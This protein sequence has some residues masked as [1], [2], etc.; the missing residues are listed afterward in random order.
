MTVSSFTLLQPKTSRSADF[1]LVAAWFTF[2]ATVIFIPFRARGVIWA[3]NIPLLYA[4]YTDFLLFVPDVFMLIS[5]ALWGLSLLTVRRKISLGPIHIW[6]PLLGLTLSGWVSLVDSSDMQLTLYHALR[7]SLLFIFIIFIVNELHSPVWV[8][9]PVAI[10][11]LI[12]SLVAIGQSLMQADLGLQFF[13][14][15]E[16]DPLRAGTSIL[17]SGGI[18]FLRAYGLSDHPNILGGCL[19]FGLL[20]LLAAFIYGIQNKKP[21]QSW[22]M[23][24]IFLI[25]SLA[26]LLTFSRSAWIAFLIGSLLI[27]SVEV[28]RKKSVVLSRVVFLAIACLLAASPFIYRDLP[29]LSGR[30]NADA[31]FSA[32]RVERGS[33]IE[34]V[35]LIAAAKRIFVDHALTGVGLGASV[36]AMQQVYSTFAVNYQPPHLTLLASALETGVFGAA[37][38]FI[39]SGYPLLLFAVQRNRLHIA[40]YLI[41]CGAVLLAILIVG[42]FD[43]YPWGYMTGRYWQWMAWG[44][45]ASAWNHQYAMD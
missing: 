6:V 37:F 38:F 5:L 2:A 28:W 17:E 4:D 27:V 9:I 31:S 10:Q 42:I 8:V 21:A 44:L 24:S 3:R 19:A 20:I 22:L 32:N 13:G 1:F 39:L 45:W 30:F 16:L 35:Y 12:Q 43:Y 15:H 26:L 41:P 23:A 14:E 25:G 40:R 29:Y 34:R 11:V 33:I 36:V 18:R 7:F